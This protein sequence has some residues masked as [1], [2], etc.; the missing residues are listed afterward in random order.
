MSLTRCGHGSEFARRASCICNDRREAEEK[1]LTFVHRS[2]LMSSGLRVQGRK[3][4][5]TSHRQLDTGGRTSTLQR[6]NPQTPEG[7][8]VAA[9][10]KAAAKKTTTTRKSPAKKV[11]SARKTPAPRVT[12]PVVK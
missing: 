3:T 4:N 12:K 9:T 6:A 8:T 11:S 1:S 7:S 10:K 5:A 2:V